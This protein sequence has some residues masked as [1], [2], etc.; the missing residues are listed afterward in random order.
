MTKPMD[1]LKSWATMR[2]A[3]KPILSPLI[4]QQVTYTYLSP[5][6]VADQ[7]STLLYIIHLEHDASAP[8]QEARVVASALHLN[9][10]ARRNTNG[11]PS[12]VLISLYERSTRSGRAGGD[13]NRAA[14]EL[15]YLRRLPAQI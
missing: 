14:G 13:I 12:Q 6:W 10:E 1:A 2:S 4:R 7:R 3:M 8:L 5:V 15:R 9:D 11:K